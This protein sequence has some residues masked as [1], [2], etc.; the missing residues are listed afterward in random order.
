VFIYLA[1]HGIGAEDGPA[2]VVV[3]PKLDAE[4]NAILNESEVITPEDV[5]AVLVSHPNVT[6]K[7]KVMSCYSGRFLPLLEGQPNV[8]VIETSSAADEPSLFDIDGVEGEDERGNKVVVLDQSD[9][10][11]GADEFTNGNVHGLYEWARMPDT[12]D[13]LAEGIAKSFELGKEEDFARTV[14]LTEPQL[15]VIR[16]MPIGLY[17]DG[18]WRFFGGSTIEV[19]YQGQALNRTG[20]QYR[21]SSSPVTEVVV[22]VPGGRTITNHLCPNQLPAGQRSGNKLTCGGG[23]LPLNTVFTLNVQ[24]SPPPS[25]GMGGQISA[26]QDG[27]LKG[28]FPISGP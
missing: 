20:T 28:P 15:R 5:R 23:S 27:V 7:I 14:G 26:R 12:G 4:G 25:A 8:K 3:E 22:E 6:F 2:G 1:G 24:T 11:T 18:A 19:E 13:G 9:N 17:V 16:P 10:P 21:Q